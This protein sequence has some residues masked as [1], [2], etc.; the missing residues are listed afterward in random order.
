MRHVIQIVLASTLLCA[1][2]V[3]N[4][5]LGALEI[6]QACVAEGCF[7]G[8]GPGFPVT[9]TASGNYALTG[10]LVVEEVGRSAI[11][12]DADDVRI[13]LNGFTI[14]GPN[15]CDFTTL[16]CAPGGGAGGIHVRSDSKNHHISNGHVKGFGSYCIGLGHNSFVKDVSASDCFAGIGGP[17]G[18]ILERVRAFN[19]R[20][21]VDLYGKAI[22]RES[23]VF[24]NMQNGVQVNEADG[25][26][27][28]IERN[29]IAGNG[30][31]G[32]NAQSAV[33]MIGNVVTDN[34]TGVRFG[35]QS[36]GS[37]LQDNLLHSNGS[38]GIVVSG[39]T[40]GAV[41]LSGN[42]LANNG[43]VPGNSHISGNS[44]WL[45]LTPSLC[46]TSFCP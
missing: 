17:E 28:L 23:T 26:R 39:V 3:A 45:H 12:V 34:G 30:A 9:L 37:K 29:N 2:A 32:V 22:L 5:D 33:L 15:S 42:S 14:S 44:Q 8:D 7:P 40:N 13:N 27:S 1:A 38:S 31:V 20:F 43:A 24:G 35:A 16:S 6:N 21:G 19:N 36:G 46:G 11:F 41:A 25:R 18:G 10:N 4:A